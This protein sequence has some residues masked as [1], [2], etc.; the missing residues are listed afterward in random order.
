[1]RILT[2][3]LAGA[4]L[5]TTALPAIAADLIIDETP[6]EVWPVTISSTGFYVGAHAGP[7]IVGLEYDPD[8]DPPEVYQFA[9]PSLTAGVAFGWDTMLGSNLVGGVELRYDLF[10]AAFTPFDPDDDLFRFHDTISATGKLGYL[11]APGTQVYGVL[12]FGSAGFEAPEGFADWVNGRAIGLVAGVGA[13]TRLTDQL[14]ANVDL[15]YFSALD[16]FTTADGVS[17]LPRYLAVT[18]GLKY[19]FDDG[20][21]HMTAE[22]EQIDFDF[23]GPNVSLSALA[24]AASMERIN[25]VTPGAD[26]G[27]FWSEGVGIGIG[28]GYDFDIGNGWVIGATANLD[29]TPL[30]FDDAAGNGGL[31]D[32]PTKFATVDTVIS[33]GVRLGVKTNPST[34]VYGKAGIAGINTHAD[35]EFFALDGGGSA[36]LPAV[37]F[38]L[39]VET[40]IADQVTLGVEGNYTAATSPLVTDN[41]QLDQIELWPTLLT[42]KVTLKYHF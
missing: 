35:E 33:A 28:L 38:G 2:G 3:Y 30:V 23:T 32:A 10:S 34:L 8:F 42:G 36:L 27:P 11:V 15:R 21:G 24:V 20:L 41:T 16:S 12:G 26:V 9:K 5:A 17:F 22:P 13:E 29:Y 4:L 18:A 1:M 7:T 37:Q 39:G 19:R 25:I 14:S 40:A 6:I 31:V